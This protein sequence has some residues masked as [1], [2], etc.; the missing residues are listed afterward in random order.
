MFTLGLDLNFCFSSLKSSIFYPDEVIKGS[1]SCLGRMFLSSDLSCLE[2]QGLAGIL[3][4][5]F[6]YSVGFICF[7]LMLTFA[8]NLYGVPMLGWDMLLLL[9]R[10]VL[11]FG[12][13][14]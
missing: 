14:F 5:C 6:F 10:D 9:F 13:P 7:S 1:S 12:F 4:Y 11:Y 3:V 8:F 2:I